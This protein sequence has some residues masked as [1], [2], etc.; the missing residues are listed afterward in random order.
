MSFF[1]QIKQIKQMKDLQEKLG[2]EKVTI[3]KEGVKVSV[4]GKMEVEEIIL[5]PS[6][7]P[8]DQQEIVKECVNDAMKKV[9]TQAAKQ[10]LQ[11]GQ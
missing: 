1:D 7:V 5:N 2:Q 4:N 6:I 3:E 9:Q 11:M 10:F 8:Q